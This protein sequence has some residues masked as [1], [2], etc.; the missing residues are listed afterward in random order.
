MGKQEGDIIIMNKATEYVYHLLTSLGIDLTDENFRDTPERFSKVLEEFLGS[1]IDFEKEL[2]DIFSSVFKSAGDNIIVIKDIEAYGLCPHH[3]LP[4]KYN[5]SVVYLPHGYVIGLSKVSRLSKLLAKKALL[6]EV[7]T[8]L[9]A[10]TIIKYLKT[11]DVA[12]IVRG[13][14]L[15]MRM[16]GVEDREVGVVVSEMRGQFRDDKSLI[17]M[18]IMSLLGK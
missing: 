8:S 6:Q 18:E 1:G 9:I 7:Y 5:V 12:V 13:E 4:V 17:R 15:C 2:Q 10:E 14:H 11:P 16:R 3:L